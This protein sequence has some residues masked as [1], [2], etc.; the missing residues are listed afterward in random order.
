MKVS[1]SLDSIRYVLKMTIYTQ[2]NVLLSVNYLGGKYSVS[3]S[4]KNHLLQSIFTSNHFQLNLFVLFNVCV[5]LHTIYS[6][7]FI[8]L[9]KIK[10]QT[11]SPSNFASA[12]Y[13]PLLQA[14]L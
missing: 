13:N 3:Q 1:H 6:N 2:T 12:I 14:F 9:S 4:K 7:K 5:K 10:Y 11:G 8:K